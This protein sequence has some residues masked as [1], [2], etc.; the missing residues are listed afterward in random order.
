MDSYLSVFQQ[1]LK[2]KSSSRVKKSGNYQLISGPRLSILLILELNEKNQDTSF[3]MIYYFK[4]TKG[5]NK[6]KNI[7][8]S[9]N[10]AIYARTLSSRQIKICYS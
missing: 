3:L 2:Y 1:F 6:N 7:A 5:K 4:Y 9:T 8:S 10:I